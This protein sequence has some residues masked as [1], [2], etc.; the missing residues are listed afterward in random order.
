MQLFGMNL[1]QFSFAKLKIQKGNDA[2]MFKIVVLISSTLIFVSTFDENEFYCKAI[3]GLYKICRKCPSLGQDNLGFLPAHAKDWAKI[4]KLNFKTC[5]DLTKSFYG[6]RVLTLEYQIN[7][8]QS[9]FE[10]WV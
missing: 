4:S 2:K 9:L 5:V 6:K 8:Q 1:N 10:F 7:V 3:P